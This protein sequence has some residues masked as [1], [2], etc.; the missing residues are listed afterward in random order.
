VDL[1]GHGR[2]GKEPINLTM[3][4][5]AADIATVI[6]HLDLRD[7]VLGGWSMGMTAIY[8][9]LEQWGTERLAG[10]VSI[11]MTPRIL[12]ADGWEHCTYGSLDAASSLEFQHDILRDRLAL[13]PTI[14]TAMFAQGRVVDPELA[15]FVVGESAA[16]P[17]LTA[18][19]VWISMS[20]QDWRPLLPSIDVPVL[21]A[22]GG[23][24]VC[25]PTPVYEY[26]AATI[27]QSKVEIFHDSGHSLMIEEPEHFN[28][29]LSAF[30]GEL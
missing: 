7:V 25:Y 18:L 8:N 24:S 21:I 16:V 10:V 3:A 13:N 29:A 15:D 2:S 5:L 20:A 23:K 22:Q 19:A 26:L 11:D 12:K 14:I 6:E 9:Y 17:D 28:S 27:P 30:A 4:Q 1:R